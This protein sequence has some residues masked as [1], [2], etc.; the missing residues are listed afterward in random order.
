MAKKRKETAR[1]SCYSKTIYI[2]DEKLGWINVTKYLDN[3]KKAMKEIKSE[4]NY[5]GND[6]NLI[7]PTIRGAGI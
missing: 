7:R 2:Y 6:F 3:L 5:F 1:I 4:N